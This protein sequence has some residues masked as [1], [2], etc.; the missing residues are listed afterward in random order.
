MGGSSLALSIVKE[1]RMTALY[2]FL[3][4]CFTQFIRAAI[5]LHSEQ[6][7]TTAALHRLQTEVASMMMFSGLKSYE[8]TRIISLCRG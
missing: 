1:D 2:S 4:T 8:K 5:S 6:P 7:S 3:V